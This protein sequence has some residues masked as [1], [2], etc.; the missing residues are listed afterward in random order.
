VILL[1]G[2]TG[3]VGKHVVSAL[4]KTNTPI[5]LGSFDLEECKKLIGDTNI[6]CVHFDFYKTKTYEEALEGVQSVFFIRPPQIGNPKTI[7]PFID[8]MKKAKIAHTVFLSLM[9]VEKNPI[10]PHGKIEKYIKKAG[11]PYTFIRPGFFMENLLYPHGKDIRQSDKL[12]VPA[13]NSKTNFIAAKDIGEVIAVC[14]LEETKHLNKAYTLTGD[15]AYTYKEVADLLSQVLRRRILYT[16]PSLL[17][18]RRHMIRQGFDKSY[19]NVTVFLYIM[20]RLGTA[21]DKTNTVQNLLNRKA[22]SLKSFLT[23][24]MNDF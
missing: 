20:T 19:V 11:L 12:I 6:E 9:G 15:Y 3:N 18:Y 5:R 22:I 16:K 24:H 7:Y 1:I 4:E 23:F 2:A 8:A 14:L 17:S 21:K 13:G 10:P